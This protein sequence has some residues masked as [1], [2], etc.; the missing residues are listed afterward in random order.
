MSILKL[1]D[2]IPVLN[3]QL[4]SLV[5]SAASQGIIIATKSANS[6]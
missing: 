4:L 2:G 5:A 1:I 3:G 6:V